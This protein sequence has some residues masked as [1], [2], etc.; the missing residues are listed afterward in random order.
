MIIQRI[1]FIT[2][3]LLLGGCANLLPRGNTQQPSGFDSFEAAAHAFD[4]VQTYRTT[5]AQLKALGFDV[6]YDPR[7]KRLSIPA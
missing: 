7:K 5:V 1:V 6:C 4:Q 3:S 2:A